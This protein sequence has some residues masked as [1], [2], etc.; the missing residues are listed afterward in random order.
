MR[1]QGKTIVK[2]YKYERSMQGSENEAKMRSTA[3]EFLIISVP[4]VQKATIWEPKLPKLR[5]KCVP[6][7]QNGAQRISNGTQMG[8]KMS[9]GDPKMGFFG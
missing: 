8:P 3:S 7:D 6:K 1:S 2:A 9:A 4:H 5:P